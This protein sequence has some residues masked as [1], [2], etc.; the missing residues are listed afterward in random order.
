V[1]R[2]LPHADRVG[3]AE[4]GELPGGLAV[5]VVPGSLAIA[6][7]MAASHA[8]KSGSMRAAVPRAAAAAKVCPA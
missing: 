3:L 4:R 7:S 5:R 1:G 2:L 8:V 6:R